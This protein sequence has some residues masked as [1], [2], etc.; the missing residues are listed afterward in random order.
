MAIVGLVGLCH[1][2]FLYWL[3]ARRVLQVSEGSQT[4]FVG[5]AMIL[6][7]AASAVLGALAGS[8]GLL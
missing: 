6:L 4:E 8:I 3:G 1:T 2:L 5:I 7:A